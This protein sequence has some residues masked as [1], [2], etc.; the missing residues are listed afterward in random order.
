MKCDECDNQ[1]SFL[2]PPSFTLASGDG[3][4]DNAAFTITGNELKLNESADFETQNEYTIR[5]KGTD[6][7]GLSIEKTFTISVTDV[8]EN[9]APVIT[10][11]GGG[12]TAALRNFRASEL[13]LRHGCK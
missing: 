3:D 6:P 5:V 10:S 8:L 7:G 13:G 4:T 11:N 1:R 2:S 9:A 12:E